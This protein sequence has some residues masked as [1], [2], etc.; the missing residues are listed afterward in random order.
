[1]SMLQSEIKSS[2]AASP[3]AGIAIAIGGAAL[4]IL[5]L[6]GADVAVLAMGALLVFGSILILYDRSVTIEPHTILT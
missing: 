2:E 1:M 6:V 5:A 3:N 4:A